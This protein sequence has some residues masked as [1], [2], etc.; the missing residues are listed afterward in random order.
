MKIK[1][2]ISNGIIIVLCL[3]LM[4]GIIFFITEAASFENKYY[5]TE[6]PFLYAIQAKDYSRLMEVSYHN[7]AMKDGKSEKYSEYHGVADYFEAASFY[8]AYLENGE[9][10]KAQR[11]KKKMEESFLQMGKYA[12]LTEEIH[13][14]L[15]LD[16]IGK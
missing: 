8:G 9:E 14:I 13:K 5:K 12:Y 7:R 3:F 11:M 15:G 6:E 16:E 10:E 4:L 2:W 1:K